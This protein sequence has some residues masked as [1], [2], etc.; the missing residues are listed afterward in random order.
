MDEDDQVFERFS[1]FMKE[2]GCKESFSALIDCIEDTRN[3]AKCK[4]H[5]PILKKCMDDRISYYEPILALAKAGEDK[6]LAF[7]IEEIQKENE[8]RGVGDS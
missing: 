2:G 8:P 4:E 1:D 6:A 3:M 7:A 5:L